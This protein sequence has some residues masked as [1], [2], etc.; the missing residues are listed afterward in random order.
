MEFPQPSNPH[1]PELPYALGKVSEEDY[2]EKKWNEAQDIGGGVRIDY[3]TH[4]GVK[5]GIFVMHKHANPDPDWPICLGTVNF[6]IPEM[7]GFPQAKWQVV[8]QEPL[9]LSPSIL[10]RDCGLHGY[11][12]NGRWEST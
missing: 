5:A 10:R 8:S 4:K 3:F 12:R 6:D 11:I 1:A 9:T 2:F 7:E